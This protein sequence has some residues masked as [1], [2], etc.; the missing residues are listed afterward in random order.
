MN[1]RALLLAILLFSLS[2]LFANPY[3]G[4]VSLFVIDPGHGG[5]DPGAQG[6]GKNEKDINLAVS[7]LVAENLEKAGRSAVLTRSDDRFLELG[8]RCDIANSAT[9][10]KSGYPLFVSIHVNSAQNGDA[11]G[12][13]VFVKDEKKLIP[14][15]SKVTN[16]ILLS[17]YASYT[18]SQLNRYKDLVSRRVADSVVSSVQRSFPLAR[19]RG[20]KK[21]DLY[22]L[23]CTWMPSILIELGFISNEEENG[24]LGD[25][26]W[27]QRMAAAIS[28]AL[29]GY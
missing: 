27:Q 18:P 25:G 13:E 4:G 20:V 1:R 16:P 24:R 8:T 3:S 19:I 23:N 12:F 10:E 14:M 28:D 7:L 5:K 11:S 17:K 2:S 15:L 29:L 9:F 26:S 22:V 21:G 6:F